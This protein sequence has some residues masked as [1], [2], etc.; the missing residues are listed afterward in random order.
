MDEIR[1]ERPADQPPSTTNSFTTPTPYTR[2]PCENTLLNIASEG[3]ASERLSRK[4][5]ASRKKVLLKIIVRLGPIPSSSLPSGA[6]LYLS[7][8][9]G[10]VESVQ[11]GIC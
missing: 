5:M 2:T 10:E 4:N 3:I 8:D 9:C 7:K 6:S 11:K 1:S